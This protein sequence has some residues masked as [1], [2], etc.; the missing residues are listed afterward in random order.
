MSGCLSK[1]RVD[2]RRRVALAY[3]AMDK[4]RLY[5]L[6]EK[7]GERLAHGGW[8]R[9]CLLVLI[10]L[11]VL[12]V[13]LQ[14]V[15]S[16]NDD[17]AYAFRIFELFSVCVFSFEYLLR[18]WVINVGVKYASR[19][20]RLRYMFSPMALVD[21][22]SIL[23]SLLSMNFVDL[24][25]L[26]IA[27]LFRLLRVLKIGRYSKTLQRFVAVAVE[28]RAEMAVT[29]MAM[30]LLLVISSGAM[31]FVEHD[32]QPEVFSSI[33]AAM[34]WAVE[35]LSTV[36]Y[37]DI[38]PITVLGKLVGGIV[39]IVGIGMFALPSGILGAAFLK[40]IQA[41]DHFEMTCPH[42]NKA[43]QLKNDSTENVEA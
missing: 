16:I 31:Y 38:Y 13:I 17:F 7:P 39:A 41:E 5:S 14:S 30:L 27:R 6:L 43:I 18:L 23:P 12:S 21:V 26:R 34:W 40:R 29:F 33:P 3:L 36:G 4:K 9:I 35:T 1:T 19:W 15:K 28:T 10:L 8:L 24:R 22:V 37:G 11:N 20:G 25:F 42:C 32:A 2:L